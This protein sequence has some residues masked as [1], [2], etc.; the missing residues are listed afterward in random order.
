[1]NNIEFLYNLLMNDEFN[2]NNINILCKLIPEII[3][4]INFDH[5]HPHHHLNVFEHT[6]YAISISEKNF[7]VRLTLLLHDIGKPLS[8]VKTS[9]GNSSFIG[10]PN[11]SAD[12][13]Y[14]ILCRLGFDENY[15]KKI[16]YLVK[17]HDNI[18]PLKKESFKLLYNEVGSELIDL[19]INVQSADA[20]AHHPDFLEKRIRYL[21]KIKSFRKNI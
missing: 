4:T 2:E 21:K 18:L 16:V 8:Q 10:H 20:L 5:N 13:T 14:N 1:M 19:L 11:I 17:K 3:P 9:K 7:D 12:M 15:I 6:I